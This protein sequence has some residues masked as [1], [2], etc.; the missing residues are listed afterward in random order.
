M[1]EIKNSVIKFGGTSVA[2]ESDMIKKITLEE[3]PRYVVVSAPGKSKSDD[4]KVTDLLIKLNQ[5]YSEKLFD[6][7]ISKY[8]NLGNNSKLKEIETELKI[9]CAQIQGLQRYEDI[10]SFGEWASALILSDKLELPFYD[11]ANFIQVKG[12]K[13]VKTFNLN[14]VPNRAIIPGFYGSNLENKIETLSRGGSD[15]TGAII[16]SAFNLPYHNFTDS[17]IK[18]VDPRLISNPKEISEMTF[19]ELR[20]LTLSGFSII[21]E[22]VWYLMEESRLPLIV[23]GTKDYPNNGTIV[24]NERLNRENKAVTGISYQD[25]FLLMT[26]DSKNTNNQG[27]DLGLYTEFNNHKINITTTSGGLTDT[28]FLLDKKN[29]TTHTLNEL[30]KIFTQKG[31]GVKIKDNIACLIVVGE[32]LKNNKGILGKISTNISESKNNI[33]F[34]SQSGCEKS[35]IYGINGGV[36]G[37]E[38][39]QTLYNNFI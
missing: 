12:K 29:L 23:R 33:A 1:V 20:Y 16:A 3:N 25:N 31:Y 7:I 24:V 4:T 34:V 5:N 9:R 32:E 36:D 2:K 27:F 30:S 10:V 15:L 35:I 8:E 22:D 38:T 17:P 11:P 28:S 39:L 37:K 6:E 21:H 13:F 18:A 19:R 26:I 14:E